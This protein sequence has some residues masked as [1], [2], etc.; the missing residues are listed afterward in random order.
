MSRNSQVAE[1]LYV[2]S[3]RHARAFMADARA[4]KP[5]DFKDSMPLVNQLLASVQRNRTAAGSLSKLRTFDEYTY[6]HC[7]NVAVLSMAFG[8][9][10]G[11]EE[12][13]LRLLGLAGLYHDVG[14]ARIPEE[15]LNK[16]GRLTPEE[17]NLMKAHPV[18][19]YNIMA[20][21]SDADE[22]VLPAILEH[23]ERGRRQRLPQGA[24]Q[25]RHKPFRPHRQHCG[26]FTTP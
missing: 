4:G 9:S 11:M 16:P 6:T 13:E 8:A 15:I 2:E 26:T 20:G 10:L 23:H 22:Q 18:E 1:K 7:I 17:F 24:G 19:G 5:L 3:L 21:Q 14:K 12:K 25:S